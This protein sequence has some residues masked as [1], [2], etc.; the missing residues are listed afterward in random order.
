MNEIQSI[1][2]GAPATSSFEVECRKYICSAK[3]TRSIIISQKSTESLPPMLSIVP[4]VVLVRFGAW[5]QDGFLPATQIA[6]IGG[7]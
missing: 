6:T 3:L 1:V 7:S 5:S 4:L 2:A